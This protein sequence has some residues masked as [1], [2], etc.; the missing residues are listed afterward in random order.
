MNFSFEDYR[1]KVIGC[2]VGKCVGGTLGMKYEGQIQPNTVTY[3]DPVPTTMV[4]NDDLD[5]QVVNLETVLR[6]GLPVSRYKLAETWRD[7]ISDGAPDEYGV[8]ISNQR[9][10]IGA[11]LSGK[12]RNKMNAGM[13]GAIRSELWACAAPANPE[14]ASTLAR[15]DACTDHC[16]D[17]VHA[18]MFLAALESSAFLYNSSSR[19][20]IEEII[21]MSLK[22]LPEGSKMRTA[23][24]DVIAWW[25]EHHDVM[26]VRELI[27][28]KYYAFNWT[29]VTINLSFIVLSLISCE[30]NF[31]KA[32][33]TAT[34]LAY[35]ADCTAATVGSVFG[36][37]TPDG[38]D[39]KWTDPIGNGLVL[40]A[41]LINMHPAKT[42]NEFCDQIISVAEEVQKF[43]KTGV[44]LNIPA[45][46]PRARIAKPYN[47]SNKAMHI[48][49]EGANEGLVCV[50][51][52]IVSVCYPETVAAVPGKENKYEIK[53]VNPTGATVSGKI[54]LNLPD[55]WEATPSTLEYS[56]ESEKEIRVPFTVKVDGNHQRANY[57][58][59]SMVIE[60]NGLSFDV[61]AGLPVAFPWLF[62]NLETGE[63]YVYEATNIFF[64]IP[65]GRHKITAKVF[66]PSDKEMQ[67]HTAARGRDFKVYLNGEQI[68]DNIEAPRGRWYNPTMH[69]S[70]AYRT[71]IKGG[72]NVF[73]IEFRDGDESEFFMGYATLYGCGIWLDDM[74]RIIF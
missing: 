33:C 49:E 61:E 7:H 58:Q 18:E 38:I 32:I 41:G 23:F 71:S 51:P 31:D 53:L 68:Y 54:T 39:S 22:Y 12:Y 40:S 29:D 8:A 14:L 69:R 70:G 26:K 59:L 5:L 35:D 16:S 48:W 65:A 37:L 72:L 19:E 44:E 74:E 60:A 20:V 47:E 43:Y 9:I 34:N 17:G 55:Y 56:V 21:Q 24:T 67:L 36:I 4:P 28:D 13:G 6:T 46:F 2:F 52:L 10:K 57:N 42:V 64:P 45:D 73:E 27:L 30:G 15:E 63:K 66:C 11:P 50:N 25:A 62:E 1:K 3:Y